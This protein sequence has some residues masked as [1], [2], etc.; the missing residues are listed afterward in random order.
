MVG[1]WV[2]VG[3]WALH[4]NTICF[5][6]ITKTHKHSARLIPSVHLLVFAQAAVVER[7]EETIRYGEGLL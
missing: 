4:C 3:R 5:I 6:D 2:P 7:L 1:T